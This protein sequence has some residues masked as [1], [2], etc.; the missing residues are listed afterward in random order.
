[1][2]DVNS[3]KVGVAY[4]G[5]RTSRR[6]AGSRLLRMVRLRGVRRAGLAQACVL[7]ILAISI[8]CFFGPQFVGS[9][10]ATAF[11][12]LAAPTLQHPMGTDPL[13]RDQLARVMVGGQ[14]SLIVGAVVAALC[15]TIAVAVGGLSGYFGGWLETVLMRL[16]EVFQVVPAIILALVA[17]AL[18]GSSISIIILILA[19]TMWPQVARIVRAETLK[20]SELGYVESAKAIGFGPL[21][22]LWSDV[23]PNVFPPVLVATTM[24]A[25]RAILLESGLAFLGLGDA[26]RP[27]WGALLNTAQ[28]HIQTAWWLTLYPGVAIFLIVLAVNLLGDILNDNLNP[29]LERVK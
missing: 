27:S 25:G 10:T 4:V 8:V 28:S 20:I 1:M 15:L 22:I 14:T 18:L 6:P 16:A 21:H 9:P 12:A 24:T 2:T 3:D 17:V 7:A 11:Q 23:L 13:G 26:N 19:A 5:T 29:V